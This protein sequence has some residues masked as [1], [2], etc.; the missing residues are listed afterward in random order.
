[1]ME[2]KLAFTTAPTAKLLWAEILQVPKNDGQLTSEALRKKIF[3]SF[4]ICDTLDV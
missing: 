2:P 4:D 1:M 3:N